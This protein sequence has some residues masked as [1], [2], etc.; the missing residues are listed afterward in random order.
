M[1]GVRDASNLLTGNAFV[2]E[3]YLYDSVHFIVVF[4]INIIFIVIQRYYMLLLLKNV[5]TKTYLSIINLSPNILVQKKAK[6]TLIKY[7]QILLNSSI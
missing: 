5:K 4:F 1:Y 6:H 2:L 3:S 7:L